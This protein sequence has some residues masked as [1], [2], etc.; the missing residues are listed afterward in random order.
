[1]LENDPGLAQAHRLEPEHERWSP[2]QY[3]AALG[4]L[5]I[6][7]LLVERGAE[8]YT[9]PMNSY[10]PVM[11]AS[12]NGHQAVVDYFLHEIPDQAAD[13]NRLGM[14]PLIMNATQK[15][16]CAEVRSRKQIN[17]AT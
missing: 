13:T 9:N 15:N 2:L 14:T 8:V 17:L 10:P 1:L 3:A 16:D 12:W 5:A 6:C 4:Q 7:R 11:E